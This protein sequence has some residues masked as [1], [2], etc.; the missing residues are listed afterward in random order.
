MPMPKDHIV[1]HH[2]LTR[3]G[4]VPDWPGIRR[5][6]MSYR[7]DGVMMARDTYMKR[8]EGGLGKR[9]EEPWHDIGYH[10]GL[11]VFEDGKQVEV[12]FGRM[13]DRI[14]A[15]CR[16]LGMNQR[17]IGI[18]VVGDFDVA[19]PPEPVFQKLIQVCAYFMRAYNIPPANV[20]GHGEAQ[21]LDPAV[22]RALKTCPGINF[23]MK[24]LRL[25][26]ANPEIL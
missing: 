4:L 5:Y 6:H 21:V 8:K 24:R 18:C 12:L 22:G 10:A 17:G 11:E 25:E 7:I 16:E 14:G 20:I 26:L 2:S 13:P 3:D 1:I 23:D 15:H 19:P 9:F